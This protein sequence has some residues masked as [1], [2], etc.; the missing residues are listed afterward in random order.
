MRNMRGCGDLLV[1]YK[2][3][4]QGTARIRCVL[5]IQSIGERRTWIGS[6]SQTQ[7]TESSESSS[8]TLPVERRR[9]SAPVMVQLEI[10]SLSVLSSLLNEQEDRPL[11]EDFSIPLHTVYS[12]YPFFEVGFWRPIDQCLL[13][14]ALEILIGAT[15]GQ[16][17]TNDMVAIITMYRYGDEEQRSSTF[18][19]SR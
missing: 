3:G 8:R 14:C 19:S 11:I 10:P 6:Q 12:Q 16:H 1:S 13:I 17:L 5:I 18:R 4:E 2:I 15:D 7:P 9:R